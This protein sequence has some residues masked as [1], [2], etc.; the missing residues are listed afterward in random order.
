MKQPTEQEIR[1]FWEWCGL[2][3]ENRVGYQGCYK[4]IGYSGVE[5]IGKH[6]P[7]RDLNNL[8]KYAI[9]KLD[10]EWT[11][12]IISFRQKSGRYYSEAKIYG[13][14]NNVKCG[15]LL[16]R[17]WQEGENPDEVTALALFWVIKQVMD[18]VKKVALR[19]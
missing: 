7:P 11:L 19:G 4:G 6:L 5:R 12:E 17:D 18:S 13:E 1:E 8:F 3:L 15:E 10:D 9:P 16:A 2:T 14:V